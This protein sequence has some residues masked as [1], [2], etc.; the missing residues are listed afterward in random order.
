MHDTI[1]QLFVAGFLSAYALLAARIWSGFVAGLRS[2]PKKQSAL[3]LVRMRVRSWAPRVCAKSFLFSRNP[4]HRSRLAGGA[5]VLALFVALIAAR[6]SGLAQASSPAPS[7]PVQPSIEGVV[8]VAAQG[9]P[10][11]VPGV[12]ITLTATSSPF[13]SVMA[14]TDADGR[15]QVAG[16]PAGA[17][18]IEANLEG[19]KASA[20]TIALRAGE[21]NVKNVALELDTVVQK[22]EVKDKVDTI[23]TQAP[24][25]TATISSRK[26][27]T[28]P[29]AD[30]K[31][32]SVLPLVPGVVRT[33]DGKLNIKGEA[34]N[35]GMLL[36]DSAQAVDPVTGSFSIPVS[37]DAI[38]TLSVNKAAYD[39]QYGGFSGGLT[40]IETKPPAGDWHYG[41]MDF[42]PGLRG[43]AGHIVGVSGFTPRAYFGGPIIKDKLNFSE[44]F[45]Y[46]VRKK[47]VRGLPWPDN[48]TKYQ[49]F[50]SLS[51][52]QAVLSPRHLLS[53]SV[54]AFSKRTQFGDI[55]ALVPQSASADEGHKGESI[56]ASDSYQ[57]NSG[58]LLSTIFRYTHF[59]SNAHGQGPED[60]LITPEGWGGNF[61]NMWTRRT[62]QFEFLPIYRFPLKEWLGR[63][64]FK[65]GVDLTHRSYNVSQYSHP[66]QLF[67]Q[68]GSLAE[69]IDFAGGGRFHARDSEVAEFL[70]DHWTINGRLALDMGGRFTSQTNGRSAAFAPRASLAYSPDH[71]TMI[72]TGAGLFYGR[73]P[74]LLA[75]FVD[76]PTRVVTQYDSNGARDGSPIRY[77]NSFVQFVPGVGFVP[78]KPR[79]DTSPRNFTYNFEVDRELGRG[80]ALRASY[81]YSQTQNL[82]FITPLAAVSG[83]GSLMGLADNGG[84]HY[85]E[86]ETTLHYRAG[87]RSELNVSYIHSR[88]RG[89]LNTLSDLYVPF[90]Q[91]VI[92]PDV[93]GTFAGDVPHRV[94]SWGA[95]GLP[96]NL[97]LSPVVD[98]HS[99]LPY[100][101]VDTLQNYAGTPN[102]QRFPTFFSLDTKIYREFPLH[103][104]F[105]GNMKNRK[106]RLG[107]YTLN[108]TNHNNPVAIYNNITSP[109]FGHFVGFQHRVSGFVIDVVN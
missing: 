17:Y 3:G 85:H 4:N 93:S 92:R 61:F 16:L 102:G 6:T 24:N 69:R 86:L 10:E 9:Q 94:V 42:V 28:L 32:T 103:L 25:S 66:I 2:A 31:F 56:G 88:A 67:R 79:L 26:I 15:Y 81:L 53:V 43:K 38:Q 63:H 72:R 70:Q 5:Q 35:Q 1:L 87:E 60:M 105:F 20:E 82:Y 91:P 58:A 62:N 18:R 74:L 37:V 95:F 98:V 101:Q 89:D 55:S 52:F 78:T 45:T 109:Y 65:L 51:I 8:S 19:F 99:G 7:Q 46:D 50:D 73:V 57:F 90:E 76:D 47:P 36:V 33:W 41:L 29:L 100:S 48:E 54:N 80:L 11:P 59:D 108:L 12:R 13:T 75:D 40:N 84:S 39:S 49:G 96:W 104:P 83:R 30:Q 22:V 107:L 64:E 97:T 21:V 106:L 44:A 27:I 71:K 23:A 77:E 34:E 68:D 14:V